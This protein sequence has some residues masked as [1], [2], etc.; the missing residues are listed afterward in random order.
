MSVMTWEVM[1]GQGVKNQSISAK[2]LLILEI[3][4]SLRHH[5]GHCGHRGQRIIQ[6]HRWRGFMEACLGSW[7]VRYCR[8]KFTKNNVHRSMK[9][10]SRA[11]L[12]VMDPSD[13]DVMY[14]ATI[15]GIEMSGIINYDPRRVFSKPQTAVRL[16][17][18]LKWIAIWRYKEN[19]PPGLSAENQSCLCND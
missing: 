4:A 14:A 2:F 5:R 15:S 9:S 7:A 3:A 19:L 17:K 10:R 13:P 8:S 6:I 11:L 12:M 16:G 18:N 1:V